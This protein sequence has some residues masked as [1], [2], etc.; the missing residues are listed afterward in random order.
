ML[1]LFSKLFLKLESLE[2]SLILFYVVD[3]T[4]YSNRHTT[5]SHMDPRAEFRVLSK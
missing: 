4:T 3:R 2:A 1:C 5:I